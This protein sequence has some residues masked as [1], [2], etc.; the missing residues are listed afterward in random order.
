VNNKFINYQTIDQINNLD[1]KSM[2]CRGVVFFVVKL[3]CVKIYLVT[4]LLDGFKRSLGSN[5]SSRN[6]RKASM[7]FRRNLIFDMSSCEIKEKDVFSHR[8]IQ[9]SDINIKHN[10]GK[11]L[12]EYK[13]SNRERR[14]KMTS[15]DLNMKRSL[16]HSRSNFQSLSSIE[17]PLSQKFKIF[18]KSMK[19]LE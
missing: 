10:K 6:K 11:K 4:P 18:T 9:H 19:E 14:M 15:K 8:N 5:L 16:Q 3:L 2:K 7:V 17:D 12:S 1:S 13:I